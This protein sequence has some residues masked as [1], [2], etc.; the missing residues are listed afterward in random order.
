[1]NV[2]VRPT[3]EPCSDQRGFVGRVIIHDDMDVEVG[4]HPGVDLL[5]EIE[6]SVAGGAYSICRLRSLTRCGV[7]RT[8]TSS[9]PDVAVGAALRHARHHRQ[10]R[11]LAVE[12]WI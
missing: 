6:E 4:G 9:V 7:R 3:S 10:N 1:V 8:M 12:R 5:K 11:L 2:V